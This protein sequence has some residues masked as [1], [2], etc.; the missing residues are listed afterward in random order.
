[1]RTKFTAIAFAVSLGSGM[2]A[3]HASLVYEGFEQ[4]GGQGL[5]SANTVLTIQNKDVEAGSVSWNG[6]IDVITGDAKTGASQAQTR[7]FGELSIGSAAQLRVVFNASQ[8]SGQGISLNDLF[9]GIYSPTGTALWNSSAFSPVEYATTITG[10]GNSGYVFRLDGAQ[11]VA[12]QS[13]LDA[14][15]GGF[16]NDRIGLSASA[17]NTALPAIGGL[18][19]F[20]V[21]AVPEA[22]TYAMIL[23]GFGLMTLVA[24]RRKQHG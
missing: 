19:T 15:T 12:L 17:G 3:A 4:L 16:A 20:N 13:V 11:A 5:G 1:M 10:T 24:R 6:V 21:V 14:Q 23:A 22:D 2:T 8:Q 9:L 18:E 7:T